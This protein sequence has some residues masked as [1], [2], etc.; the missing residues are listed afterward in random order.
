[1][2]RGVVR[3]IVL[4]RQLAKHSAPGFSQGARL[5]LV[6]ELATEV[7]PCLPHLNELVGRGIVEVVAERC[8]VCAASLASHAQSSANSFARAS[9]LMAA[10]AQ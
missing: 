5:K 4:G 6:Q 10:P 7:F 3:V 2:R 8:C 1:L 9:L